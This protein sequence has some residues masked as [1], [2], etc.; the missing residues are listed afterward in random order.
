MPLSKES[1][2]ALRCRGDSSST[3][4]PRRWL[5]RESTPLRAV[6]LALLVSRRLWR[7][8]S[9][10][11]ALV[12]RTWPPLAFWLWHAAPRPSR[13]QRACRVPRSQR[14][15]HGRGGAAWAAARPA[16]RCRYPS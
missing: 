8:C 12:C 14:A 2:L 5:Q 11:K 3:T 7:C 4:R 15:A 13:R 9:A 1:A 10:S 6:A 16:W